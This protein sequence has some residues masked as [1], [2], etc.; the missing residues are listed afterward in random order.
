MDPLATWNY[1]ILRAGLEQTSPFPSHEHLQMREGFL[2][3]SAFLPFLLLTRN[4]AYLDPHFP[5]EIKAHG[6]HGEELRGVD[7]A[8]LDRQSSQWAELGQMMANQLRQ[9][10]PPY[11][12]Q[13]NE[14]NAPDMYSV[15]AHCLP[16]FLMDVPLGKAKLIKPVHDDPEVKYGFH[17]ALVRP[18]PKNIPDNV[19]LADVAGLEDNEIGK[20]K[21]HERLKANH[22]LT[23][24]FDLLMV[25]Q[26][27]GEHGILLSTDMPGY[28]SYLQTAADIFHAC[29]GDAF[30]IPYAQAALWHRALNF[31]LDMQSDED[32]FVHPLISGMALYENRLTPRSFADGFENFRLALY[33]AKDNGAHTSSIMVARPFEANYLARGEV[34][35]D[36]NGQKQAEFTKLKETFQAIRK[37]MEN[38]DFQDY[39]HDKPLNDNTS[40]NEGYRAAIL[41][42]ENYLPAMALASPETFN[43]VFDKEFQKTNEFW[44]QLD[45]KKRIL[46]RDVLETKA[47]RRRERKPRP[48]GGPGEG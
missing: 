11:P 15:F 14:P 43:D 33:A 32:V 42:L 7:I 5:D 31:G 10:R 2:Q 35:K 29:D 26:A 41:F 1:F 4:I 44:H 34:Y 39:F 30:A 20:F 45:K 48:R 12:E 22:E 6:F 23:N 17:Y 47:P 18:V 24:F 19:F 40:I 8:K 21:V 46:I 28:E 9:S 36:S 37:V 13:V 27:L 38:E 25:V 16:E 3:G